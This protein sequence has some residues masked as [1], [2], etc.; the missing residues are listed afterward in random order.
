LS[1][2]AFLDTAAGRV[3]DSR[4]GQTNDPSFG[5]PSG[6]FNDLARTRHTAMDLS[7]ST[8]RVRLTVSPFNGAPDGRSVPSSS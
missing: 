1:N 5:M 3:V 8:L 7:M 2:A 4:G 6:H